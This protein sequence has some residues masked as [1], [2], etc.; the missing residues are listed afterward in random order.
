MNNNAGKISASQ[1]MLSVACFLQAST[2]LT[3][4][5]IP[6]TKQ[7][8]WFAVCLGFIFCLPLIWIYTRLIRR[9]PGLTLFQIHDKVYGPVI[10]TL[11]SVLYLGF[12]VTL[13]TLNLRDV[14]NFLRITVL[15]ETPNP[16]LLTSF[17]IVC[18]YAVRHGL[19]V[20]TRYSSLFVLVALVILITSTIFT[21]DL[22]KLENFQPMFDQPFSSYVHGTNILL[23]IPF[24]EIVV[25]L[26][27]TPDVNKPK[28]GLGK[29]L[30]GG[31]ALGAAT[32]LV[33]IF[34]DTAVLGNTMGLFALPSFETLRMVS[35]S[36]AI[37]RI[38]ILFAIAL[39][40]LLFLKVSF[41][42][43]VSAIGTSHLLRFK[44][45]RPLVLTVGAFITTYA[46]FIY[47][48][49]LEHATT[50]RETAGILWLP[51]DVI[52]PL[53]TLTVAYIRNLPRKEGNA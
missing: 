41:L 6:I 14:G 53:L 7:D 49:S 10:G 20:V 33:V 28:R 2:L 5:F 16:V 27:I 13:A 15:T 21:I 43:Y 51:Y 30:L 48:S 32:M 45:F 44:S 47:T 37:S 12:F 4:F 39:V 29:Y 50:A 40:V 25:F 9:F 46:L 17:I 23:T 42:Y 31:L 38:E 8:S 34:R 19:K 35:V 26:M 24:G 3:S 18:A 52:L 1:Y 36:Q 22:M 11:V